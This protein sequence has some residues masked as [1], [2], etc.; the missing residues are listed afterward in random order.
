MGTD[1]RPIVNQ[2]RN[3]LSSAF[4]FWVPDGS[5]PIQDGRAK[6]V[7]IE[8][9]LQVRVKP[10]P[11]DHI[12]NPIAVQIREN[13]RMWFREC[14]VTGVLRREIAH[15]VM[16]KEGNDSCRVTLLLEPG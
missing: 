13:G 3:K 4:G 16:A 5:I 11:G 2:F 14:D 10:F 8:M 12:R 6:G 9:A 7:G 1:A 15:D